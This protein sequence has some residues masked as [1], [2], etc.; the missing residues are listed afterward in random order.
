[1]LK[2]CKRWLILFLLWITNIKNSIIFV[3]F[4]DEEEYIHKVFRKMRHI[5]TLGATI[6]FNTEKEYIV[7]R[8]V[9]KI[10]VGHKIYVVVEPTN[11]IPTTKDNKNIDN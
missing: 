1:M 7:T 8:Y 11:K 3:E 10:T 9:N 6:F 4:I 5:P 2:K